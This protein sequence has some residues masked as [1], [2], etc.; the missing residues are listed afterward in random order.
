M[1]AARA[2]APSQIVERPQYEPI[3]TNGAPGTAAAASRAAAC[4]ASPS[5]GGMKPLAASACSRQSGSA[6]GGEAYVVPGAEPT[7]AAP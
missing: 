4:R 6:I 7:P 3:S 2:A 1:P 5:S